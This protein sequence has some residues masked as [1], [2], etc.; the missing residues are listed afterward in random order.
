MGYTALATLVIKSFGTVE[1][2][3]IK[4]GLPPQPTAS[5][6]SQNRLYLNFSDYSALFRAFLTS[7][8]WL[9]FG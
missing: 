7:T 6:Y 1:I 8:L 2:M 4:V 9:V 5:S 3:S